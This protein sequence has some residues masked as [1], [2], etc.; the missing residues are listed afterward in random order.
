MAIT[1]TTSPLTG[2]TGRN[3]S[4]ADWQKVGQ[5]TGTAPIDFNKA[6]GTG[7][8]YGNTG[9][10]YYHTGS[11]WGLRSPQ[12]PPTPVDPAPAGLAAPPPPP[13]TQQVAG[14]ARSSISGILQQPL[15]VNQNDPAFATQRDAINLEAQRMKEQRQSQ[16]AERLSVQGLNTG[17]AMDTAATAATQAEGEMRLSGMSDLMGRELQGQRAQLMQA[18][19]IAQSAGLADQEMAL[20][21]RLA[22]LDMAIRR[23]GYGTQERI[24]GQD[25]RLRDRLGTGNLNLGLLQT[26]LGN[27]QST[28]RLGF[29]IGQSQAMFDRQSL[30]DLL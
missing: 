14:Q 11:G 12:A 4:T 3:L 19:Q 7:V 1:P 10:E 6:A 28:D 21:E 9:M 5:Q 2:Y 25:V 13:T 27:Q 17:G 23:E 8:A 29:D 15:G 18:L 20:R 24:A 26:L 16:A 30:L 22:Q